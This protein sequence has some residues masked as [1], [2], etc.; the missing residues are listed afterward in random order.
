MTRTWKKFHECW[1]LVD[2]SS[3]QCRSVRH[4]SALHCIE[5]TS[6]SYCC[7]AN[8]TLPPRVWASSRWPER[9][10]LALVVFRPS[11]IVV[12]AAGENLFRNI[13]DQ[14]RILIFLPPCRPLP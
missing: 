6:I 14:F 1:R 2:A 3:L 10:E 13:D 4:L 12:N 8:A 9:H 11:L 5:Y 7:L